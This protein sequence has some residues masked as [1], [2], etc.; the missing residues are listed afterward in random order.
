[1]KLRIC[2]V[3]AAGHSAGKLKSK[4]HW[5]KHEKNHSHGKSKNYSV[6]K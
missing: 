3:W 1:M 6:I 4:G 2:I 5:R